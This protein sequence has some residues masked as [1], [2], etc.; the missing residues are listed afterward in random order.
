ME[1]L[2]AE[3]FGSCS[4]FFFFIMPDR[5]GDSDDAFTDTRPEVAKKSFFLLP[6]GAQWP[7]N[8]EKMIWMF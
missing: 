1:E 8:K 7:K 5:C 6:F 2:N 3:G 4:F